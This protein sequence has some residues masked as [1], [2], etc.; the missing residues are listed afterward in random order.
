M[1]HEILRFLLLVLPYVLFTTVAALLIWGE[2]I[3]RLWP[4]LLVYALLASLTQTLTYQVENWSLQFPAEVVSGFLVA[5]LVFR[6]KVNWIFKIYATS[7]IIGI[8]YVLLIVVPVSVMIFPQSFNEIGESPV[9]WLT[10]FLPAYALLLPMALA[11]RR[12][13][14]K[15]QAIRA[16]L[17]SG[18]G[19]PYPVFI[20]IFIQLVLITGLYTEV[21]RGSNVAGDEVKTYATAITATVLAFISFYLVIVYYKR[22]SI[23]LMVSS[24]EGVSE[25]LM[26]LVNTVRGQRHDMLNQLQVI[27]GLAYQDKNIEL[28]EYLDELIGEVSAYSEL[29]KINNPVISA[30]INAKISQANT[31]GVEIDVDMQAD[32]ARLRERAM[33]FARILANLIDNAVESVLNDKVEKRVEISIFKQEH[34]LVCRVKNA[35][36]KSIDTEQIFLPGFTSKDDHSG[37]GLYNCLKLAERLRGKL[38]LRQEG[39]KVIFYF[40]IPQYDA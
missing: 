35:S 14:D 27:Y 7:Y 13:P 28:K 11:V 24:Q 1:R 40:M 6:E 4:R 8:V 5:W 32:L 16:N 30:L 21:V 22:Q 36:T 37:L 31:R 29:L 33:D 20:A 15:F 39:G 26:D 9:H 17:G 34:F 19:K 18:L 38:E 25:H 12:F 3:K 23:A 2:D 10:Y